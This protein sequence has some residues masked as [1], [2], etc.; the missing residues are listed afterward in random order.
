MTELGFE[1]MN[2]NFDSGE[3]IYRSIQYAIQEFEDYVNKL[4]VVS[5]LKE[6]A[7]VALEALRKHELVKSAKEVE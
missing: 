2:I 5:S 6:K 1:S 7:K 3:S 4:P